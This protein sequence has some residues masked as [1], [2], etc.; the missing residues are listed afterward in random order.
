VTETSVPAVQ[1]VSRATTGDHF[2]RRRVDMPPRIG[3]ARS[4]WR[5]CSTNRRARM[6][7]SST[8]AGQGN[9]HH[10][11]GYWTT[12]YAAGMQDDS[13]PWEESRGMAFSYGYNRA[14]RIGDYKSGRELVM[15]LIDLSAAAAIS[16]SISA[17]TKTAP[18][19]SSWS[20]GCWKSA[21][22]SRSTARRFMVRA[23][24]AAPASGRRQAP[25]TKIR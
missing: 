4:C 9:P 3:R 16:C 6:R 1:D 23:W 20:S 5:G 2:Q 18:S 15:V 11:G 21:T 24:Q 8:T 17:R 14:E 13:H 25:R 10:H 19:R 22:G 12:E 7:S